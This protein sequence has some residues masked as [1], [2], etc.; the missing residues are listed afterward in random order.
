MYALLSAWRQSPNGTMLYELWRQSIC[1]LIFQGTR[2]WIMDKLHWEWWKGVSGLH[3]WKKNQKFLLELMILESFHGRNL[4][5]NLSPQMS[6]KYTLVHSVSAVTK[7][8][9]D[10]GHVRYHLGFSFPKGWIWARFLPAEGALTLPALCTCIRENLRMTPMS[11]GFG[12]P[13]GDNIK[14]DKVRGFLL[15]I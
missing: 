11:F 3:V 7:S 8:L 13:F 2:R 10:L 5:P 1:T 14:D 4:E 6:W 15:F 9:R 12:G